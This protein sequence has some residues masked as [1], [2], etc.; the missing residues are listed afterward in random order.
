MNYDSKQ[1]TVLYAEDEK[2]AREA[3]AKTLK[4]RTKEQY[5]ADDGE[6]AIEL[7][8][9]YQPDIVITDINM[10]NKNGIELAREILEINPEQIIRGALK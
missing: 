1:L 7:Y 9:Q 4:R 3:F 10:P 8:R 5:I 6:K 2:D